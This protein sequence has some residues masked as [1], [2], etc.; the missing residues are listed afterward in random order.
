MLDNRLREFFNPGFGIGRLVTTVPER[1]LAEIARHRDN[2]ECSIVILCSESFRNITPML[3]EWKEQL[4]RREVIAKPKLQ[5]VE[6]LPVLSNPKGID[7]ELNR[8]MNMLKKDDAIIL[9][10]GIHQ[11]NYNPDGARYLFTK[12]QKHMEES[13]PAAP[14]VLNTT[15]RGL[16]RV[17]TCNPRLRFNTI[18][19]VLDE[20]CAH[21][22]TEGA[23]TPESER[24]KENPDAKVKETT[25][26]RVDETE[27]A[28]TQID[29]RP[30]DETEL[31]E[32]PTDERPADEIETSDSENDISDTEREAA[33][34]A[35]F[36]GEEAERVGETETPGTQTSGKQ[37]AQETQETQEAHGEAAA[38]T[39]EAEITDFPAEAEPQESEQ[40][41][42]IE[43]H[44][45]APPAEAELQELTSSSEAEPQGT[46]QAARIE[47]QKPVSPAAAE[48]QRAEQARMELQESAS[49]A[50]VE[51]QRAEQA[52]ME[53]QEPASR[54]A[55][56]KQRAEQA[57]MELQE[58]VS[59]SNQA[60]P[61]HG[62]RSATPQG[63]QRP[64]PQAHQRQNPQAYQGQ[65]PQ[66]HQRH[67]QYI[68]INN[69]YSQ[70]RTPTM[71]DAFDDFFDEVADTFTARIRAFTK[72]FEPSPNTDFPE[73]YGQYNIRND[74]WY[75]RNKDLFDKE[76]R[77]IV[78][79]AKKY[80]TEVFP[81]IAP[82]TG[83]LTFR[84]TLPCK[85]GKKLFFR[86]IF[87]ERFSERDPRVYFIVQGHQHY[88]GA[89]RSFEVARIY[90]SEYRSPCYR[91]SKEIYHNIAIKLGMTSK[92]VITVEF[93]RDAIYPKAMMNY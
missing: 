17:L 73:E 50:A 59:R 10:N 49:T 58:P 8:I 9:F 72:L 44:E 14:L 39:Q 92:A 77:G 31:A 5:S 45:P 30:A 20:N 82:Q 55:T 62:F 46:E 90:D 84:L 18:W 48:Q 83:R 68:D 3:E 75:R 23:V 38:E 40:A 61:K 6:M 33:E 69:L 37:E 29:E 51:Q 76:V 52:R 74:A 24:P 2:N 88:Q 66:A 78:Y 21:F 91:L 87:D 16:I 11:A 22:V 26:K 13:K 12:L 7:Y 41:A 70:Q 32:I 93:F 63:N 35:P 34:D 42:H 56:E 81:E 79:L 64:N 36:P 1:A 54:A 67:E 60:P 80:Q 86:V 89:F 65:N 19:L 71:T 15:D 47:P 53:L 28:E 25:K 43:P 4:Y 57:R 27:P 85:D